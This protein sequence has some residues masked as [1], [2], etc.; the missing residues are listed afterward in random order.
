MPRHSLRVEVAGLAR[1]SRY[2]RADHFD[3]SLRRFG[4][5]SRIEG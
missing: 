5:Q 4:D 2:D 1:S 3:C